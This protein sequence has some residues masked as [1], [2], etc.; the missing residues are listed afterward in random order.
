MAE[1]GRRQ[2]YTTSIS[3]GAETSDWTKWVVRLV[4]AIALIAGSFLSYKMLYQPVDPLLK[5]EPFE[6][7]LQ[8]RASVEELRQNYPSLDTT[9][10]PIAF[11]DKIYKIPRNY[12]V[13]L[14]RSSGD[15]KETR[16]EIYVLLPNLEPRTANNADRFVKSPFDGG[17]GDQVVATIRGG[18][19]E[20]N[21][22]ERRLLW[23]RWCEEKGSG[24]FRTVESGYQLCEAANSD[25]Y[26]KD[27]PEGPL[28]FVCRKVTDKRSDCTIAD[29]TG[30]QWGVLTLDFNRKYVYQ[31][32][33]I[34]KR[35]RS[36]L[37]SFAE[38]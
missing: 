4:V 27:T 16:F 25:L 38:E 31:A 21:W 19:E 10:I 29:R 11:G 26:L 17:Y 5:H 33:E 6:E 23:N 22:S 15:P 12:L 37:D 34:R 9:T 32:D 7:K 13:D 3:S 36:L 20:L 35:F 18:Q 30:A 2:D 14:N 1:F 28:I 24:A 8:R